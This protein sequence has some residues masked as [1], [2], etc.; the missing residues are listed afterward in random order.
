MIFYQNFD[1]LVFKASFHITAEMGQEK[2]NFNFIALS[3]VQSTERQGMQSFSELSEPERDFDRSCSIHTIQVSHDYHMT[4]GK[5]LLEQM[6]GAH[7]SQCYPIESPSEFMPLVNNIMLESQRVLGTITFA[8][9]NYF[10][11]LTKPS[12]KTSLVEPNQVQPNQCD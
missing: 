8:F 7:R 1:I 5:N 6:V 9:A 4:T 11:L 12:V 2:W 3:I 10:S